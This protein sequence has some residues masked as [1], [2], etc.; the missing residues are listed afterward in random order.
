MHSAF[1]GTRVWPIVS[2][3]M[4]TPAV[5]FDTA[6]RLLCEIAEFSNRAS[7]NVNPVRMMEDYYN[8]LRFPQMC[9]LI[10]ASRLV[11]Y[12][13]PSYRTNKVPELLRFCSPN[14]SGDVLSD[15]CLSIESDSMSEHLE[16]IWRHPEEFP[17]DDAF[18]D[19][20]YRRAF[21]CSFGDLDEEPWSVDEL[22]E[23]LRAT[24]TVFE[25]TKRD[26]EAAFN[27][28]V[29]YA[30]RP[31]DGVSRAEEKLVKKALKRNEWPTQLVNAF[32]W[33][34]AEIRRNLRHVVLWAK[35]TGTLGIDMPQLSG[36]QPPA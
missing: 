20:L 35:R 34:A 9:D 32:E 25:A 30:W 6:I 7:F 33:K 27:N 1:I 2:P 29:L 16:Y 21:R 24:A 8:N 28:W 17:R 3:N 10:N 4:Q 19:E 18:H 15:A 12:T 23:E 14:M 36:G 31:P 13:S 5:E 26:R 11:R 22:R